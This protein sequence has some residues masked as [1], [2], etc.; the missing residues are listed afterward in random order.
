MGGTV[1]LLRLLLAQAQAQAKRALWVPEDG[2]SC[3]CPLVPLDP[4]GEEMGRGAPSE[5]LC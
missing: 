5:V 3:F 1:C 4:L 2:Q